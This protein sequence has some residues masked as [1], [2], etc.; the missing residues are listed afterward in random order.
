MTSIARIVGDEEAALM[1]LI[2]EVTVEDIVYLV[3]TLVPD[4]CGIPE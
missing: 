3:V 4:G 1:S 2:D